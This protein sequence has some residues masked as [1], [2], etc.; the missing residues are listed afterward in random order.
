MALVRTVFAAVSLMGPIGAT[1]CIDVGFD[2]VLTISSTASSGSTRTTDCCATTEISAS[3]TSSPPT[4]TTGTDGATVTTTTEADPTNG[5]AAD[6]STTESLMTEPL[7]T[8]PCM[9]CGTTGTTT[10]AETSTCG[11][12]ACGTSTSGEPAETTEDVS[13]GCM[14]D[15]TPRRVFV[16]GMTFPGNFSAERGPAF[17]TADEICNEDAMDKGV[18]GTFKAWISVSGGDSPST[19]FDTTFGG[20]YVLAPLLVDPQP[21]VVVA[22]GWNGLTAGTLLHKINVKADGFE[23]NTAP[24]VWTGTAI[25][26]TPF[27]DSC[28]AW[29]V[30][31]GVGRVGTYTNIDGDWTNTTDGNCDT[32]RR[33]YCFEDPL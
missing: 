30:T 25:D 19:R 17:A 24:S 11:T 12:D 6:T 28:G 14:G 23:V 27:G 13:T 26:G 3:A 33:L 5:T 29:D 7:M 9:D 32:N 4:S 18:T 1:G 15:C 22:I 21:P 16:T 10:A 8:G 2:D 20:D 31:T